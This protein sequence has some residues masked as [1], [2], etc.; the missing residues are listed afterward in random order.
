[1]QTR[2]CCHWY[3]WARTGRVTKRK[4]TKKNVTGYLGSSK[5]WKLF[6]FFQIQL[7]NFITILYTSISLEY[8]IGSFDLSEI[9]SFSWNLITQCCHNK[10][11][12]YPIVWMST[13][14]LFIFHQFMARYWSMYCVLQVVRTSSSGCILYFENQLWSLMRYNSIK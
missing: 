9:Q 12:F 14:K 2:F 10:R 11:Y 8:S 5:K 1:M 7:P 3:Y 6:S 4:S 13:F